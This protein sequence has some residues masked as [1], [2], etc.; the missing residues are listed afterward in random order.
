SLRPATAPARVR[1]SPST[2]RAVCLLPAAEGSSPMILASA[3][4]LDRSTA[5]MCSCR[6][7]SSDDS[8]SR[9]VPLLPSILWPPAPVFDGSD[10]RGE[11]R[12]GSRHTVEPRQAAE[13]TRRLAPGDGA[14]R[15]GGRDGGEGC[16]LRHVGAVE[17]DALAGQER[18]RERGGLPRGRGEPARGR[19]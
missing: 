4:I 2:G 19:G 12:A 18:S 3:S 1:P 10:H 7:T 8:V 17:V 9:T 6:A 11:L 14:L 5:G 15:E 16:E 13:Q